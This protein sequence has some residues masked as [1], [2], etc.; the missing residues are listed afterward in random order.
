MPSW[1]FKLE[2]EIFDGV[3]IVTAGHVDVKEIVFDPNRGVCCAIIGFNIDVFKPFGDLMIHYLICEAQW[4]CGASVLGDIATE[5]K[6]ALSVVF[7]SAGLT[8]S[9]VTVI[10]TYR[11]AP[12]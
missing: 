11:G 4:V 8:V 1:S 2:R 9:G 12:T 7:G 6:R 3:K 5:L 10:V